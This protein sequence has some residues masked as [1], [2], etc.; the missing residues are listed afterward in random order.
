MDAR[1]PSVQAAHLREPQSTHPRV[2]HVRAADGRDMQQPRDARVLDAEQDSVGLDPPDKAPDQRARLHVTCC[3]QGC[4]MK[5][6][7]LGH[8][9]LDHDASASTCTPS[10]FTEAASHSEVS[11]A[12]TEG[13]QSACNAQKPI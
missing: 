1:W 13:R 5:T 2:L 7:D 12:S 10:I 4:Q 3:H 6:V 8:L 9:T 11:L